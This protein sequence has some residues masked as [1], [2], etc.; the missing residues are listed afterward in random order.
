MLFP[1]KSS[2][3][4]RQKNL[5]RVDITV[6]YRILS[7]GKSGEQDGY[8]LWQPRRPLKWGV[9]EGRQG[10][11]ELA[12]LVLDG[13]PSRASSYHRRQADR[14]D[15]SALVVNAGGDGDQAIVSREM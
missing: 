10:R 8:F 15:D 13:Q 5:P 6:P 7:L 12:N 1:N 14:P 2:Q 11:F 9:A 4:I 3:A